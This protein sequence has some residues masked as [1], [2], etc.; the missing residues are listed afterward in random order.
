MCNTYGRIT[1]DGIVID[2]PTKHKDLGDMCGVTRESVN[3]MINDLKK[4]KVIS[5]DSTII[6]VHNI[7]YLKREIFCDECPFEV[8][9]I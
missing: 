9:Q 2:L 5:M 3:R 4:R 7:D 6:T 8:C 1:K